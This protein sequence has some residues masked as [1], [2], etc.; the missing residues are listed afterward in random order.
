MAGNGQSG[1]PRLPGRLYR[2]TIRYRPDRH[3]VELG[4]LLERLVQA[5]PGQ[6]AAILD[7][8]AAGGLASTETTAEETSET[9]LLLD[10]LF[11]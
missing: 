11:N 9:A 4:Q 1:R 5:G 7:R 2:L 6:R 3:S 8:V 10:G